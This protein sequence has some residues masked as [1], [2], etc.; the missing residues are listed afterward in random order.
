MSEQLKPCRCGHAGSLVG[1]RHQ[2]YLSL[3]CPECRRSVEAFTEEG[4]AEAWNKPAAAQEGDS[5]VH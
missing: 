3:S 1:I 4:L 5:H 2:G